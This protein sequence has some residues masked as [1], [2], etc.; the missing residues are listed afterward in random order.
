LYDVVS[1]R[2]EH[3]LLWRPWQFDRKIKHDDFK[4]RYALK[5]DMEHLHHCHLDKC[6]RINWSWRKQKK[7]N[8]PC[9]KIMVRIWGQV[10]QRWVKSVKHQGVNFHPLKINLKASSKINKKIRERSGVERK[11]VER[12]TKG[13][14]KKSV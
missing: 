8:K 5:K 14:E 2:A 7:S 1:M 4:N 6:T 11:W 13:Q 3:L 12:R 10:K 9:Y